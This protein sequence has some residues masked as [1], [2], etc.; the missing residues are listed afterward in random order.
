MRRSACGVLGAALCLAV[1]AAA[2][3]ARAQATAPAP[4]KPAMPP[5]KAR[6]AA[7]ARGPDR[8]EK[9][10]AE[11]VRSTREYRASLERLL[12]VYENQLSMAV[13]NLE[14]RRE[15]HPPP[16]LGLRE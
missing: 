10:A 13:Q 15:M 5:A 6:P 4:A 3:S 7:P 11:V 16:E 14:V 2:A 8:L 12:A 9:L 1:L